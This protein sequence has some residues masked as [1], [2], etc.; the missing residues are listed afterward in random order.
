PTDQLRLHRA[1][2]ATDRICSAHA[3]GVAICRETL[4][5][6]SHPRPFGMRRFIPAFLLALTLTAVQ[7]RAQASD[8]TPIALLS[9][10]YADFAWEATGGDDGPGAKT[11]SDQPKSAL[12]R[13]VEPELAALLLRDAA[14]VR[15]SNAIC[16]LDFAPLWDSQDPDVAD[17]SFTHSAARPGRVVAHLRSRTGADTLVTYRMRR[18]PAGWRIADIEYRNGLSLR[19]LLGGAKVIGSR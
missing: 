12:L 8:S 3:C 13:Y 1:G 19:T 9:R 4:A 11:F 10:L 6:T 7:L 2:L 16:H 5:F 18:T 15:R 17:V 14:C